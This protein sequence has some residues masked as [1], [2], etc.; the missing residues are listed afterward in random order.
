MN[1]LR[2]LT[3][4]CVAMAAFAAAPR[5]SAD[6][7]NI[8][9]ADAATLARELVG[10]GDTRARAIVAHRNE[11]GPFRSIEELTLVKGIG[12]RVIEQNRAQLR[13]EPV[14]PAARAPG[15]SP[16]P[17]QLPRQAPPPPVATPP[18]RR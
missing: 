12:P 1:S 5:A 11:N 3:L 13:V 8:N 6:P 16:R 4:A 17:S 2:A 9:T 15:V 7:V 14:R 10:V 18:A